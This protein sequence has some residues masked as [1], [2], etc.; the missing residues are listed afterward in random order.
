[1]EQTQ[2]NLWLKEE[3]HQELEV[4]ARKKIDLIST[5]ITFRH[6]AALIGLSR[7]WLAFGNDQ[8][9]EKVL[10]RLSATTGERLG[11]RIIILTLL[12]VACKEQPSLAEQYLED[13]LRLAEPEGYIRTFLDMGNPLWTILQ[14]LAQSPSRKW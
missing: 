6:E 13:A 14:S 10:T 4:F 5:D 8:E 3:N 9:A 2:L 1:M 7:A 11:S 12:A